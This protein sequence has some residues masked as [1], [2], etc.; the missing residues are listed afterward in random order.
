MKVDV[1]HVKI[2]NLGCLT[3]SY[4]ENLRLDENAKYE[5]LVIYKNI[6]KSDDPV[7]PRREILAGRLISQNRYVFIFECISRNNIKKR[8]CINKVDYI[9]NNRLIRKA[10]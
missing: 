4:I 1:G 10:S 7:E 3:T 2:E 8:V 6:N 9:L 5:V